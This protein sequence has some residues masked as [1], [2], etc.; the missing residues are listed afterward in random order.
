MLVI[1]VY[2]SIVLITNGLGFRFVKFVLDLFALRGASAAKAVIG[3]PTPIHRRSCNILHQSSSSLLV[4]QRSRKNICPVH[5]AL[6]EF[7]FDFLLELCE[8][9]LDVFIYVSRF[10]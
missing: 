2:G 3:F 10:L 6:V 1:L 9:L 7:L 5:Q 8:F 4:K